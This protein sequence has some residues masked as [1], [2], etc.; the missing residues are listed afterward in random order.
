MGLASSQARLLSLT[1]RQHTIEANAQR[2]LSD[3]MRL[4]NQ[5]DAAYQKYMNALD[6]TILK[7]RQM[8]AL[9]ETSWIDG[10]VINL[11]RYGAADNTSGS[12]FYVQDL[13]DNKLYVPKEVSDNY[14]NLTAAT[15]P[16]GHDYTD[17]MKFATLFGIEYKKVDNNEDI[18]L[19]YQRAIN[20]GLNTALTDEQYN[21]Y[22]EAY[23][24]DSQ[25][26]GTA[27]II[28]GM[29]PTGLTTTNDSSG[30]SSAYK[31]SADKLSVAENYET[32]V[33]QVLGSTLESG[34]YDAKDLT[35]MQESINLLKTIKSNTPETK[36]GTENVQYGFFKT[37]NRE[38]EITYNTTKLSVKKSGDS[39]SYLTVEDGSDDFTATQKFELMLNGGTIHW[40]GTKNK[41]VEGNFDSSTFKDMYNY[42]EVALDS[43]EQPADIDVY[44]SDIYSILAQHGASNLGEALT[45]L[46][47]KMTTATTYSSTLLKGWG[48][49]ENDVVNYKKFKEI[50]KEYSYYQP[51]YEYIANDSVKANYYETLYNAIT[52][53]GGCTSVND[54]TAKNAT[55]VENMIK[56]AKVILTTWDSNENILTRTSPSLNVDV[57][58]IHDNHEVEQA[59]QDYE[60]ET[61]FINQKDTN[62]DTVLSQLETERSA[63]TTEIEGIKKVMGDNVSQNFKVFS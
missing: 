61:A 58:E 24:K 50:E 15:V 38:Y 5:S 22:V 37:E 62:I 1:S 11:M 36:T 18:L 21:E 55:W 6:N 60:A 47:D 34:A 9:G 27:K 16:T 20:Q 48:K 45:K 57:K 33:M 51:D 52:A 46:F 43:S 53:A 17:A 4:S 41:T 26:Q 7:T 54:D 63:I 10:S 32:F 29:I 13:E 40:E 28:R 49:T 2:L 19:N 14:A 3:K 42:S 44:N 12:V 35:L 8:N 23:N 25:V 56:N 59:E 31:V 30:T 39:G